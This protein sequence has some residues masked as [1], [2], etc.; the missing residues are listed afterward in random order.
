MSS[1]VPADLRDL[2]VRMLICP[3]QRRGRN[4]EQAGNM[5]GGKE[6]GREREGGRNST[7]WIILL[8]VF[9]RS[10]IGIIIRPIHDC[11]II[12]MSGG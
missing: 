4:T 1:L 10:M 6:G 5:E 2:T 11:Q 7:L 3:N 12:T 8:K 9:P